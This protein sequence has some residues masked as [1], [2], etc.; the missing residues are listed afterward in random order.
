MR[1]WLAF[2]FLATLIS[3]SSVAQQTGSLTLSTEAH[4]QIFWQGASI[5]F[6]DDSGLIQIAGIPVG[7]YAILITKPG[8]LAE[9]TQTRIVPG[10]QVRQLSLTPLTGRSLPEITI[11]GPDGEIPSEAATAAGENP[12]AE[13]NSTDS[14]TEVVGAPKPTDRETEAGLNDSNDNPVTDET[15]PETRL[16][17]DSAPGR[18]ATENPARRVSD[19]QIPGNVPASP[20]TESD[21]RILIWWAVGLVA[22]VGLIHLFRKRNREDLA[23]EQASVADFSRAVSPT[24]PNRNDHSGPLP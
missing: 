10:E 15:R 21:L 16:K 17:S 14:S 20:S 18:R 6:A 22:V 12:S 4:A 7:S 11:S 1:K 19:F 23:Q 13:N 3:A 2:G 5:G 9:S 24:R 8:F